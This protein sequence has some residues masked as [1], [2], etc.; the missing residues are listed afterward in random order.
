MQ[1]SFEGCDFST[2]RKQ[3]L[4][5]HINEV[6]LGIHNHICSI[7]GKAFTCRK[8]VQRHERTHLEVKPIKCHLCDWET[9]RNDKLRDHIR[10]HHP[11]WAL[12]SGFARQDEIDKCK[13]LRGPKPR[14]ADKE[15][16]PKPKE[17]QPRKHPRGKSHPNDQASVGGANLH[18]DQGGVFTCLNN[19]EVVSDPLTTASDAVTVLVPGALSSL[20][21]YYLVMQAQAQQQQSQ[22]MATNYS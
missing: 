9:T 8:H 13:L 17:R 2:M 3:C 6:H 14:V 16:P 10:K 12:N 20:D 5:D 22:G 11:D 18:M 15:S 7:C 1:C 19:R 4:D 21:H